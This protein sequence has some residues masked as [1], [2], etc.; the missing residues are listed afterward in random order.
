MK[1]IYGV[2]A[3]GLLLCAPLGAALAEGCI[4]L[5]TTAQVEERYVDQQGNEATRLVAAA[6][7]VPGT[8]VVWIVS[9]RNVCSQAADALSID[10]PVPEHMVYVA[11]SARG[12][13]VQVSYSIDGQRFASSAELLVRDEDGQERLARADEYRAIRFAMTG[14]LAGGE[15]VAAEY[16]AL[17]E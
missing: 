6:K 13:R 3:G 7:V 14:P 15:T 5:K 12:S 11:D 10:S 16:R 8:E 1:S 2:V 9:A 4:E 17:V